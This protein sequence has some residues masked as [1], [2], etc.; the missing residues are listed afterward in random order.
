MTRGNGDEREGFFR[1]V[2]AEPAGFCSSGPS[3]PNCV[4]VQITLTPVELSKRFG[5]GDKRVWRRA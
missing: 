2:D 4:A 1:A 3:D 5:S